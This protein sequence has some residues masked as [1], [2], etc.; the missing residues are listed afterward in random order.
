MDKNT[1]LNL[2][3]KPSAEVV[4]IDLG[5]GIA[6]I[7]PA[8]QA[9][10]I[11]VRGLVS[12]D[13]A[14]LQV[15]LDDFGIESMNAKELMA[16]GIEELNQSMLKACRAG[17]AFWAAQEALKNDES[18][19][20]GLDTFKSWIESCGLAKQRVYECISIAK[21]YSW[22]PPAQ[23]GKILAIGKKQALLLAKTPQ[24]VIDQ[25]AENGQDI[26]GEAQ[27]LTYDALRDLLKAAERKNQLLGN[28]LELSQSIVAKMKKRDPVYQ[29]HPLTHVVREECLHYQAESELSLNSIWALF[30]AT[31]K[32]DITAPEWRMRLE[33]IWVTAHVTAARALDT[34]AKI[35]EAVPVDGL[36]EQIGSIHSLTDEEAER[37]LIDYGLLE[38]KFDAARMAR[39]KKRED[40]KPKGPGRPKIEK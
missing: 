30:E 11:K 6:P 33:Q 5:I 22:L 2:D 36:P 28:E 27:T 39:E 4:S 21:Y 34:L 38:R 17:T 9:P 14:Q 40:S 3:I 13:L 16:I 7:V 25:A 32:E 10:V 35:K 1:G 19:G 31:A 37:W 26:L 29:F 20:G 24:E 8:E 12:V 18:D 15:C 23:R